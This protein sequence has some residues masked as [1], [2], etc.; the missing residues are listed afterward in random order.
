M[1][2]GEKMYSLL[3]WLDGLSYTGVFIYFI[4]VYSLAVVIGV[5]Q[6][7]VAKLKE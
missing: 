4:V 7:V 1:Q 3:Q 6:T 5:V 2:N